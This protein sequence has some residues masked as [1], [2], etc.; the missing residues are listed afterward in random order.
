MKK[1]LSIIIAAAICLAFS[2]PAFAESGA[3]TVITLSDS[4]V[5]VDGKTAPQS[6]SS[7]VYTGAGIVYYEAGHDSSYG[8]GA[9]TDAHT[10]AE[11]ASHTVVTITK[12][13]TYRISGTLSAGQIAVDLGADAKSDAS[14]VVTLILDN[15][16]ITCTV[17]PAIIFYNVY[18]C[19]VSDIA[20]ASST[21]DTAKA[22]A[23]II[24]ADGSTNNI[25]GSYVA[26]IYKPGTVKKLHKYDGAVYSKMSM[27]VSG[28]ALGNGV[29]NIT[30]ANEGLDSELHLTING[31]IMNISAQDDG[32]NTNEDGV[33]VTTINGG[34]IYVNGGLGAE[35][36][37]VDSNGFLVINGGTLIAL[38]NP[39]S[40][41]GGIDADKPIL[42]NGGTVIALG[43]RNDAASADSKQAYIE[44]TYASTQKAGTVIKLTDSSGKEI[45]TFN[46]ARNYQSATISTAAM[47]AGGTYH[48]YSGGTVS[49]ATS[50]YGLYALG[51]SYSGGVQ[52]QYTG[53]GM[54]GRPGGMGGFKPA[55]GAIP[56]SGTRPDGAF[57]PNGGARPDNAS[58]PNGEPPLTG[59]NTLPNFNPG[60]PGI[61][62][63]TAAE[64][65]PDFTLSATQ[66]SFSGV[67][68]YT[69]ASGKA[70]VSFEINNGAGMSKASAGTAPILKNITAVLRNGGSAASVPNTDI[71][72]TVTDMPS[73]N[74]SKSCLL[75][76]GES[77]VSGILPT[78]AGTYQLTISVISSNQSFTGTSQWVFSVG[79]L[80]Y[81]D[82]PANSRYYN[83]IKFAFDSNIMTGTSSN[84]FSPDVSVNRAMAITVLGRLAKADNTATSAFSD[85]V[86]GS[87]YAS[88]VGWAQ[89][90]EIV[91]GYGNGKY[92]PLDTVTR[93][94][95]CQIL[96]NYAM[97]SGITMKT[98][99][100]SYTDSDSVADWAS[101]AVA[102][103]SNA[104][105]LDKLAPQGSTLNPNSELTRAELADM[106][107]RLASQK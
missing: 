13:G 10:A 89:A 43:S 50:T 40:G 83:A 75:S 3:E 30:A 104:G 79:E 11:A 26:R 36:D 42:I 34:T 29:L 100:V 35:G 71:Q 78:A 46:P 82:V 72:L 92:G 4:G 59:G 85:V 96:Y 90:N 17:A 14:A 74:Y 98:G 73:E 70:A 84:A 48:L 38:A 33:S 15:A 25:R 49:G 67:S 52:Q 20:T 45:A 64:G 32:I 24:I 88:Y 77:V 19:G 7:A 97:Y 27:N 5:L 22:G 2:I 103:C 23:N 81:Q 68:E 93:Q 86:S 6:P 37:G 1:A 57:P 21:V 63:G 76:D 87:W 95:M 53:T 65:S 31:G 91:S 44:L 101:G 80:P 51:G 16:N 39:Q 18:E 107:M 55:D 56:P 106:L 105:I 54:G 94:Q 9:A 12:A 8:E 61:N 62:T 69:A 41:D 99:E 47:S 28:G 102:F 66:K 58:P 60:N